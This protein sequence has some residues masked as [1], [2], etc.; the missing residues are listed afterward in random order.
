MFLFC[1]VGLVA[2]G[3][4]ANIKLEH[5]LGPQSASI[6]QR[7]APKTQGLNEIEA[8]TL[9]TD[10]NPQYGSIAHT[11]K[12]GSRNGMVVGRVRDQK[13][14]FGHAVTKIGHESARIFLKNLNFRFRVKI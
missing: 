7:G 3:S 8:Y 4:T 12:G 1:S 6:V 11:L 10:P 5:V 9:S 2:K 14:I 13:S